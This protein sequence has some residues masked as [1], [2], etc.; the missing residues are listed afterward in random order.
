MRPPLVAMATSPPDA[1]SRVGCALDVT[2]TVPRGYMH[3]RKIVYTY[4]YICVYI[5][6]IY[7]YIFIYVYAFMY[8]GPLLLC[9]SCIKTI[10]ITV[11]VKRRQL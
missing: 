3:P 2:A 11:L 9:Y 10:N 8:V 6:G 5:Y 7:V 1:T 4:I